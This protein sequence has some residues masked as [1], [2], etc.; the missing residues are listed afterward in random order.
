MDILQ[1]AKDLVQ[2]NHLLSTQHVMLEALER[3]ILVGMEWQL[4]LQELGDANIATWKATTRSFVAQEN[5]RPAPPRSSDSSGMTEQLLACQQA[6]NLGRDT[7]T[8]PKDTFVVLTIIARDEQTW[9]AMQ[10][11]ALPAPPVV[12]QRLRTLLSSTTPPTTDS[13]LSEDTQAHRIAD[14]LV[15]TV[16]PSR[17]RRYTQFN[18]P[19]LSN[20]LRR[21]SALTQ[22]QL[23]PFCVGPYGSLIDI[24]ETTLA[25]HYVAP[26]IPFAGDTA[27]L[28]AFER[29]C[30]LDL[31]S[32][33]LQSRTVENLR[34]DRVLEKAKEKAQ[35][36]NAILLIDHIELLGQPGGA[37]SPTSPPMAQVQAPQQT[38]AA[39][40]NATAPIQASPATTQAPTGLVPAAQ[41]APPATSGGSPQVGGQQHDAQSASARLRDHIANRGECFIVGLY[42][43]AR[44]ENLQLA[45]RAATLGDPNIMQ[46]LPLSA[47]SEGETIR[48]LES[49]YFRRWSASNFTFTARSFEGV[50]RLKDGIVIDD[51]PCALPLAAIWLAEGFIKTIG[52]SALLDTVKRAIEATKWL[53]EQDA[54]EANLPANTAHKKNLQEALKELYA[55]ND[56][57][58]GRGKSFFGFGQQQESDTPPMT[59]Q[60]VHLLAQLLCDFNESHFVYPTT[61]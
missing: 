23:V 61:F 33:R 35:R 13:G 34:L 50:F 6:W 36:E 20:T 12:E 40:A 52:A 30:K 57:L 1:R 25:D 17:D 56:R 16:T 60:P 14:I 46:A 28:N 10:G 48:L 2:N 7:A 8:P 41:P 21:I 53:L 11:A 55:L 26:K 18:S 59:V 32:L 44:G 43:M 49:V 51:K 22:T 37:A 24:L 58:E 45:I 27:A 47:L 3:P 15:R 5:S 9:A 39:P 31:A 29:V 38:Q 19:Q 54:A 4:V 42:H